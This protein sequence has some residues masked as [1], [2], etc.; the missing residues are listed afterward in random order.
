MIN[1]THHP[2]SSS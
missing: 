1:L 2:W